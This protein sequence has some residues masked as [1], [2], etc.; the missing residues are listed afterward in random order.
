MSKPVLSFGLSLNKK[1]P[2]LAK[3]QPPKR[4]TAFGGDDSDD[5]AQDAS[6]KSEQ[7]ITELNGFGSPSA[8]PSTIP[9]TASSSKLK[10]NK[11][12]TE[13]PKLKS[14]S[15]SSAQQQFGD[16]SSALTSRK[17][18]E[19]AE[20]LDPSVYDYDTAYDVIKAAEKQREAETKADPSAARKSRYMDSV[21]KAAEQRERDRGVA[22]L[23][24]I[25]REREDEGD[26]FVDKE[27]FVTEAYKKKQ[28]E[29]K[30]NEEEERRQEEEDRKK[31]KF[32]GMTGFHKEVLEREDQRR[33]EMARLTAEAAK[34]GGLG[35]AVAVEEEKTQA[36]VARAM[37]AKGAKVAVN[38]D[39]EVIDK[40][41]LLRG[42]LNLGAKKKTDEPKDANRASSSTGLRNQSKGYFGS[43]G[44][45]GMRERQTR[46]ME[47][48]LEQALKR[49]RDEE[50]EE[51]KKIE[52]Q[53]KSQKT[54][55]DISSAKERFLARKRA[56]EEAKKLG[57]EAP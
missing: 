52:Q 18:A 41:E 9:N 17:Y 19:A 14:K 51:R 45:Q 6:S 12:P 10:H 24:K 2:G 47:A 4:K 8:F 26:E 53:S 44:K 43:G 35:K 5:E 20:Q 42:G 30:R 11:V 7:T 16:L 28:E 3:A 40:R 1:K 56:A 27:K 25:Q 50:E 32:G 29:D 21:V 39:G 57:Q 15:A 37:N 54:A 48:Q 38:E 31:N 55:T 23:K 13:P 22:E 34:S 49:T 36:D 46:M 33:A